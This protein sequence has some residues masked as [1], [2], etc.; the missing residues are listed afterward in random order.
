MGE[1]Y[2]EMADL[3]ALSMVCV[4]GLSGTD[5]AAIDFLAG[6]FRQAVRT[7]KFTRQLER[8][9]S[10]PITPMSVEEMTAFFAAQIKFLKSQL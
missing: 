8:L 5:P 4:A 6:A 9:Q 1:L 10:Q 2:R 7:E 3:R